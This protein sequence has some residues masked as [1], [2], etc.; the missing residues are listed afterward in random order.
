MTEVD[1]IEDMVLQQRR[2]VGGKRQQRA[3][4]LAGQNG[5]SGHDGL[6]QL[7]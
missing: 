3:P 2:L 6:S 7:D 5:A 4:L 1:V